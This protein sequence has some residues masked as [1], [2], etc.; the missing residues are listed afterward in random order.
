MPRIVPGGTSESWTRQKQRVHDIFQE[1]LRTS[2][3]AGVFYAQEQ[4]F[5]RLTEQ[6]ITST[7]L[8][9]QFSHYLAHVYT[10]DAGRRNAGQHYSTETLVNTISTILNEAA[11]K[12]KPRST[13]ALRRCVLAKAP[14]AGDITTTT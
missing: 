1:Y 4:T 11:A 13:N 10:I 6:Q 12:W 7:L 8:Y 2:G 3:S 9:E 5:D 14:R